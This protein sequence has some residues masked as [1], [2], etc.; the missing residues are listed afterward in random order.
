MHNPKLEI[1]G[2]DSLEGGLVFI[3]SL[4]QN[5][6]E[7]GSQIQLGE[8]TCMIQFIQELINDRNRILVGS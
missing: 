1:L 7:S 3:P 4:Q 2:C 6:V 5:L 8:P